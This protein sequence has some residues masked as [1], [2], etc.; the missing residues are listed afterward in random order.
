M[1]LVGKYFFI[2]KKYTE[3]KQMI[4]TN[5]IEIQFGNFNG[6]LAYKLTIILTDWTLYPN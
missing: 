1:Y 5:T 6:K 3:N 2:F 4:T